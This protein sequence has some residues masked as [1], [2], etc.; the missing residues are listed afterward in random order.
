LFATLI[1]A[2]GMDPGTAAREV[3]SPGRSWLPLLKG[4]TP[5]W[6]DYQICEHAYSRMIC[7]ESFKLI[8]RYPNKVTRWDDELYD[9]EQDPREKRNVIDNPAYASV[10]RELDARLKEHFSAYED[11][12][13]AGTNMATIRYH[14]QRDPWETLPGQDDHR[15]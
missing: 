12:E 8:R 13:R 1:E 7:T 10:I 6:R 5:A 3:C 11:P 2:A 9:L 14:N 4:E 15:Q